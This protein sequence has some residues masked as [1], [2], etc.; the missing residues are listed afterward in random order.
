V[1]RTRRAGKAA[2]G[3]SPLVKTYTMVPLAAAAS[4]YVLA[5]DSDAARSTHSRGA[6]AAAISASAVLGGLAEPVFDRMLPQPPMPGGRT[7]R[8][9]IFPSGHTFKPSAL[10]LTAAHVLS[11]EGMVRRDVAFGF[12]AA[13]TAVSGASKIVARKHWLSDVVGGA[14]AGVAIGSLCCAGYEVARGR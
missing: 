4:L 12:A 8:Q 14:L 1:P 9:S 3:M 11:R 6:A 2:R 7:H 10:A 13:V 5:R